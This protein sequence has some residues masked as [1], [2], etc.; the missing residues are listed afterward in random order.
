MLVRPKLLTALAIIQWLL[1]GAYLYAA[2]VVLKVLAL[3]AFDA[4]ASKGISVGAI[5]CLVFMAASLLAGRGIWR[6]KLWGQWM[7]VILLGLAVA[8]LSYAWY[9]DDWDSD[10]LPVLIP[11]ALIFTTHLLPVVWRTFRSA[12]LETPA[13][14]I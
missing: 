12:K 9:D 6:Q 7:A 4:K 8:A 1:A 3:V 10:I 5:S 11:F 13:S 14:T 2:L